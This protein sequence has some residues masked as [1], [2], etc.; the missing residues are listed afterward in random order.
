MKV[1]DT[2]IADIYSQYWDEVRQKGRLGQKFLLVEGDDDRIA[3]EQLL[4]QQS[5][6]WSSKVVVAAAGGRDKVLDKLENNPT[7]FGLVDR[8]TWDESEVAA[9]KA[10]FPNL[11]ITEGWCLENHFGD[12]AVLEAALNLQEGRLAALS[13]RLPAW[14][15]YGAIRWTMKR[16][17][18]AFRAGLTPES[19]GRPDKL[20]QEPHELATLRAKLTELGY[21]ANHSRVALDD[22]LQSI[23]NR[24]REIQTL[25]LAK[26]LLLG[27]HGKEF[28]RIEVVPALNGALS[29]QPADRWRAALAAR[30]NTAWPP[31]LVTLAQRLL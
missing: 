20:A 28:F 10:S 16:C 17:R 9:K 12:S 27:A 4:R 18:D 15:S 7:W 26:Q 6:M 29:Q 24:C 3:I 8:D 14:V 11:E 30:L 23:E 1:V 21:D 2:K 13:A 25:P 19:Y 22:M 31:Y 5:P